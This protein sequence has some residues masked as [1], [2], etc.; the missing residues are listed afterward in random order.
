MLSTVSSRPVPAGATSASS[1]RC[2]AP[3]LEFVCL[4]TH[5]LRRKQKRWEDGRLKYHTF[6]KRVMVYDE[7][8]NFVGDMHW[9]RESEFGEGEEFQLERGGAIVQAIE[10]VGRQNQDLSELLD[11]RAKEKEQRQA[12]V[13]LRPAPLGASANTPVAGIRVNDHFQTRHRPL[14]QVLGTPTGPLGRAVVPTESPFELRQR[15]NEMPVNHDD[16]RPAKRRKCDLT[17]PSKMG[18]ARSLFGATLSLSAVPLSSIPR[19]Q[20]EASGPRGTGT[21]DIEPVPKDRTLDRGDPPATVSRANVVSRPSGVPLE[22]GPDDRVGEREPPETAPRSMAHTRLGKARSTS[23][24][25]VQDLPNTSGRC[26]SFSSENRTRIDTFRPP[27]ASRSLKEPDGPQNAE[28]TKHPQVGPEEVAPVTDCPGLGASRSQAIVLDED[29]GQRPD[30]ETHV[31]RTLAPERN[32]AGS[33]RVASS[34]ARQRPAKQKSP[35]AEA[36]RPPA[37]AP[38]SDETL[39]EAQLPN[40]ERTVLRLKPRQKRGLLLLSEKRKKNQQLKGRSSPSREQIH[41]TDRPATPVHDKA[42]ELHT[43]VGHKTANHTSIVSRG[44][45]TAPSFA[46]LGEAPAP[47][48]SVPDAE[49]EPRDQSIP[50]QR[51]KRK[52]KAKRSAKLQERARETASPDMQGDSSDD[53]HTVNTRKSARQGQKTRRPSDQVSSHPKTVQA[54]DSE[55]SEN[56]ELPQAEVGPHLVRLGRKSVRSREVFGFVPSSPPIVSIAGPFEPTPGI[57]DPHLAVEETTAATCLPD[58]R[59][60]EAPIPHQRQPLEESPRNCLSP[61]TPPRETAPVVQRRNS[62][63]DDETGERINSEATDGAETRRT[64]QPGDVSMRRS[65]ARRETS[66]ITLGTAMAKGTND[67][68]SPPTR[69]SIATI[70]K[71]RPPPTTGRCVNNK[72]LPAP[73][74]EAER[75]QLHNAGQPPHPISNTTGI[76]VE[77]GV[78]KRPSSP[79]PEAPPVE[80]TRPKIANPATRGRKAALKSDAAGQ[81]PRSILPMEPVHAHAIAEPSAAPRPEPAA[82]ERPKRKMTFPGFVSA[83]AGGPWSR[84][85]HDLLESGRPG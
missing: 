82:D 76:R 2:S 21:L 18:Y 26:S 25:G 51:E 39:K 44:D 28:S 6:N 36:D 32:T 33:K 84:E 49:D 23:R 57:R 20:P 9:Q 16:A 77:D 48:D 11:K 4:F 15:A 17:P 22:H 8:G 70:G 34:P 79:I 66:A 85:A 58:P 27:L 3:V 35:Q 41:A 29:T 63:P 47:G 65:L 1:G 10:C 12:R 59:A 24:I 38:E 31:S 42:A 54:A 7:R 56:E 55:E 52:Q 53:G 71:E 40:E 74:A 81:V 14:N 73:T 30:G 80:R 60:N 45:S 50:P 43:Q 83:K 46:D 68:I 13:A 19:P 64:Q 75:S 67:Q 78:T 69:Q 72:S 5:D 37:I 62:L 61:S